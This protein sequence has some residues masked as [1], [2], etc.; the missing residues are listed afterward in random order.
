MTG[1]SL[2]A[3]VNWR[4]QGC[5][6]NVYQGNAKKIFILKGASDSERVRVVRPVNTIKTSRCCAIATDSQLE[7][8]ALDQVLT[9]MGKQ[10][11]RLDSKPLANLGVRL[12][13]PSDWL[14]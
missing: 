11:V 12:N 3:T 2:P 1:R 8:E 14:I 10:V 4:T 6:S 9:G 5:Q 7:A 13:Q